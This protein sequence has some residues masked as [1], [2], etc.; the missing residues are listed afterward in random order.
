M[1]KAG[2]ADSHE[3]RRLELE[4][5]SLDQK[6]REKHSSSCGES[7]HNKG[8]HDEGWKKLGT[9]EKHWGN[10]RVSLKEIKAGQTGWGQI[11]E[12]LK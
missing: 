11:M 12:G 7:E 1:K 2:G 5:T 6:G 10:P 3:G 4:L 9:L 8:Q